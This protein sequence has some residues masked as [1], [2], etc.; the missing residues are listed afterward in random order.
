MRSLGFRLGGNA[1]VIGLISGAWLAV[2]SGSAWAQQPPQPATTPQRQ[3]PPRRSPP[4][5]ALDIH[6]GGLFGSGQPSGQSSPSYP[7][8]A[9]FTTVAGVSRAA[10]FPPGISATARVLLEQV[11]TQFADLFN[12]RFGGITLLDEALERAGTERKNAPNFGARLT[13]IL[14]PRYSVES[15]STGAAGPWTLTTGDL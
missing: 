14:S 6:G 10:L 1:V 3:P 15:T 7:V 11:R 2:A 9:A 5:W 8:G 12:Q 4:K 13:R